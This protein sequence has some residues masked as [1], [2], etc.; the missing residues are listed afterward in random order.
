[1]P[2]E[3][4]S[5]IASLITALGV[6]FVAFQAKFAADQLKHSQKELAAD[7]ERSRREHSIE[8]V[9]RWS[10]SLD[11]ALPAARKFIQEL[12][13]EQCKCLISREP[14]YIPAKHKSLLTH[15]LHE[16]LDN[17]ND[18][19]IEND[20]ILLNQN[21]LSQLLALVIK[22]L[23]ALEVALL[24][25]HNGVADNEIIEEQFQYLVCHNDD[26][27]VLGN[28]RKAMADKATFPAL[29]A[30]IRHL[31]EKRDLSLS[32]PKKQIA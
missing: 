26:H 18:L 3:W 14:F 10:D 17:E 23:N 32:Q 30:F 21:H 24:S 27:F 11:K 15:A 31:K 19:I 1:M 16:I 2:P 5:A 7:H 22:H 4:I 8:V 20:Q 28:L 29:E 12:T 9:R 6:V 13:L 25:W